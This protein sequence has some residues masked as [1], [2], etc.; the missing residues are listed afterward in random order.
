MSPHRNVSL[1]P[2]GELHRNT[3]FRSRNRNLSQIGHSRI[4]SDWTRGARLLPKFQRSCSKM[5][6]RLFHGK[7]YSAV[8]W[9]PSWNTFSGNK[10]K[11]YLFYGRLAQLYL[12]WQQCKVCLKLATISNIVDLIRLLSLIHIRLS[13][14]KIPI[15]TK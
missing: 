7:D 13:K 2:N 14:V 10:V 11:K 1:S 4:R 8:A 15:G 6:G 12:S 9:K 3:P 5:K